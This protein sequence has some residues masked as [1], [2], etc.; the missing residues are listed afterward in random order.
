MS[1]TQSMQRELYLITRSE[2]TWLVET[3]MY[4]KKKGA[5]GSI[6]PFNVFRNELETEKHIYN[7]LSHN[8]LPGEKGCFISHLRIFKDIVN[9]KIPFGMVFEDDGVFCDDFKKSQR[10]TYLCRQLVFSCFY[11]YRCHF[12]HCQ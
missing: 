8:L 4:A 6:E 10:A 9:N 5:D 1:S 7:N 2:A 11:C 3:F 12:T